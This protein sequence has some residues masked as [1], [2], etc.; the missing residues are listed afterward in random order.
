MPAWRI[1]AREVA[2]EGARLAG[3]L[4][5]MPNLGETLFAQ[6]GAVHSDDDGTKR[7]VLEDGLVLSNGADRASLLRFDRMETLLYEVR[8]LDIRKIG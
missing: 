4:L 2:N 8:V 1:E 5:Y 7:L 3:V 6:R